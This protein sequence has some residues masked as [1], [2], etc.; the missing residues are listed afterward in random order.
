MDFVTVG[1]N[2][3]K[4]KIVPVK[5]K[6]NDDFSNISIKGVSFLLIILFEGSLSFELDGIEV[7]ASAPSFI[8]F[9][10]NT[11]PRLISKKR[12]KCISVYFH[13][14]FINLNM[15]FELVRSNSYDDIASVHDMFLLKPFVNGV[16]VVPIGE[17]H[18]EGIKESCVGMES[19]LSEQR[20]WYW[21]CRSRS[22]FMEIIIALERMYSLMELLP[23]SDAYSVKDIKLRE[24]MLYIEGHYFC[25]ITLDDIVRGSG[26][27][28][29]SLTRLFRSELSMT[30]MEYLMDYRVRV[31]RKKLSFTFVPIKDIASQCGFKTVQHF[32]RVFKKYTG[33][34][35]AN[36]RNRTFE[37]RVNELG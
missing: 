26:I 6:R 17:S 12:C 4:G 36:Y 23:L 11:N 10:E 35:P 18:I 29:T 13:P 16:N 14:T 19:E 24:A 22:Y 2:Y 1:K 15:S 31:A 9:D 33:E 21:T 30:A 5:C 28:H 7:S 25:N 34:T 27:N 3:P 8:C 20:D 32:S 37:K